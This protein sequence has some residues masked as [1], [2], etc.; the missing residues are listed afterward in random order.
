MALFLTGGGDQS[1]FN[2][3]DKLDKLFINSLPDNAKI[4]L[5]PLACEIEE[6]NDVLER[7]EETF[8]HKKITQIRMIKNSNELTKDI[9]EDFDAIIIDGGNTF[10]LI[11]ELRDS[12]CFS[13]LK[14]FYSMGKHIYADS[15]GAIILG[16]DV[17]TAF[18]GDD[19]DEDQKRLQ[20]Y[21][22]LDLIDGFAIHAH[23]TS[24]EFDE[25][26]DLNDLLYDK[27]NPIL[28]LAEETGIHI[29]DGELEV[30]GL[31]R[32]ESISFSGRKTISI[33]E[34]VKLDE[35]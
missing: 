15:A 25:F 20:D 6:Y 35:L 4:L 23:A 7:I 28:A 32:L 14:S 13:L 29:N 26:D 21:R 9:I 30:F 5:I 12:S 2:K 3:L 10:K 27:G 17:Q 34:R 19:G 31:E 24:D 1:S 8:H 16:S 11:K 18:L 33:G 22:G